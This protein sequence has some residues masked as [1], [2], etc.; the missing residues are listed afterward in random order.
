MKVFFPI[1]TIGILI[2]SCSGSKAPEKEVVQQV[3][4]LKNKTV[5]NN[6]LEEGIIGIIEV[7][8]ILTLALKDSGQTLDIPVKMGKAFA[9]IQEDLNNLGLEGLG[10]PGTLFYTNDP[11]NFVFECVVPI[12]KMPINKPKNSQIFILESTR[13]LVYNYYGRY[14]K[15]Y[16]AYEKLKP[17]IEQNKLEQT[18]PSREFYLT[19]ADL[20]RDTSKWL[21]RIFIPVK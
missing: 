11:N 7:P 1:I 19:N 15:M 17:Y 6:S 8:E 9:S 14:D 20:E 5:T 3:D 10:A 13:A 4:T 12:N 2:Y 16:L 21:S 18:G